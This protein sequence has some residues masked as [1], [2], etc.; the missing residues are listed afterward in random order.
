MNIIF[1]DVDGVLNSFRKLK[2]VYIRTGKQHSGI[3]FPFDEECMDNLKYIISETDA[4]IVIN[5]SWRKYDDHMEVLK[6]KIVEYDLFDRVIAM[7][8][9]SYNKENEIINF[10]NNVSC[11]FI[12]LDD[13]YMKELND[14]LVRTNS[15]CGL[16]RENAYEAIKLLKR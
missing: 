15:Y 9:I 7:T 6:N 2:Q 4:Y 3:N 16:T 1:L 10:L 11:N 13:A 12:I 14:Y 5:S 8:D